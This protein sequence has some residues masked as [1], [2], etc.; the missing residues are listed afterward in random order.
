MSDRPSP[1]GQTAARERLQRAAM[2]F[3]VRLNMILADSPRVKNL[4]QAEVAALLRAAAEE[5]VAAFDQHAA[6]E[7]VPPDDTVT[8]HGIALRHLGEGSLP[9]FG[10]SVPFGSASITVTGNAAEAAV[11]TVATAT[12]SE[13]L[14]LS[15]SSE[16]EV[17]PA[18]SAEAR[19][20]LLSR[21][22]EVDLALRAVEGALGGIGHNSAAAG[23]RPLASEETAQVA[24]DIAA[25]RRELTAVAMN[26]D[27]TRRAVEDLAAKVAKSRVWLTRVVV[28]AAAA[29]GTG[30]VSAVARDL[31]D[32]HKLAAW[33]WLTHALEQLVAAAQAFLPWLRL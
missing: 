33:A 13:N 16:A 3:Q 32:D 15:D 12:L 11:G 23:E 22:A 2:D 26:T 25:L 30:V 14:T 29:A 8:L 5:L 10:P 1:E 24:E 20:Q 28:G 4:P 18:L 9:T 27:T 17:I 6:V 21:A 7:L 19:Q 31:Y